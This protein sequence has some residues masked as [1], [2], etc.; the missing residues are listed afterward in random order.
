M[1]FDLPKG[2]PSIIKVIGVGGGG[3]NAVNHMYGL[4]IEGVEFVVCNTDHQ[5]LDRSPVKT[6]IQLGVSLTE[7]MGAGSMPIVGRNAA[8]ESADELKS[9]FD[10][11]TKMLF[12]TA[13]MGGGTGT[14]AAPVLAEI[15]REMGVLSVG[16]VT[17]PF[18]FEGKKRLKQAQEGIEELRKHVDT[19]LVINN[20]RL[21]EMYGNLRM[22][23]AFAQ[24]DD[25]L[26]TAARGI[27]EIITRTGYVNVDF[28]DVST[29]MRDSGVAIMGRASAEGENRAIKAVENALSSPL[30]NDNEIKGARFI[31][32]NMEYGNEEITM[33]EISDITDY[34]QDEAGASADIIWGYGKNDE[35]ENELNITVI[36]TGFN[37]GNK[38]DKNR[39]ERNV[40]TLKLDDDKPLS[41]EKGTPA[42]Q[43]E[44]PKTVDDPFLKTEDERVQRTFDFQL[45]KKQFEKEK[46]QQPE[47]SSDE[48]EPFLRKNSPESPHPQP[49]PEKEEPR[50]DVPIN[51]EKREEPAVPQNPRQEK[52]PRDF[53][54]ED[55][56]NRVRDRM[57]KLKELNRKL[58]TPTGLLELEDVPAY[59]RRSVK[60]A[61][62]DHSSDSGVSRYSLEDKSDGN[63]KKTGIR[64]DNSFLH[65]NVD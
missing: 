15:A 19:L 51:M 45:E 26:S 28:Q 41:F 34:I 8:V 27:A 17:M 33:D 37:T 55:H 2:K 29:V 56:Q 13:G 63:E 64:P 35:L 49:E 48:L 30:L 7:G 54:E 22:S 18:L 20:D 5:D 16:I 53:E 14:G 21:R 65:D 62:V 39:P 4:G 32:L 42:I 36:A 60:L 6:K 40:H 9:L 25:V 47:S 23:D 24:A 61:D 50:F 44:E 1:E 38:T 11:Q 59:E 46:I 31:L 3:S 57:G 43:H 52:P 10:D 58:R 12:I